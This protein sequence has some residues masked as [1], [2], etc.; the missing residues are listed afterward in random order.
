[1]EFDN[2]LGSIT[3]DARCTREMKSRIAVAKAALK[4]RKVLF[5]SK[6]DLNVRKKLVKCYVWSMALNGAETR[7][8]RKVNQKYLES[9]EKWC[10]RRMQMISWTDRLRKEVCERIKEERNVL[11]TIQ[12]RKDWSHRA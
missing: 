11:Q 12:R 8:L 3:N 2:Y 7:S 6:L 1:V 10:W 5:T 9:F 4:K